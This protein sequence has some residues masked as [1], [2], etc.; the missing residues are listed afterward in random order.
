METP[1]NKIKILHCADLHLGIQPSFLKTKSK[2]RRTE[3]LLS[4]EKITSVCKAENI[5]LLIISG[6]LFESNNI[7]TKISDFVKQLLKDIP[8]TF[9]VI[10]AGNHDPLYAGSPYYDSDWPENVHIFGPQL[11]YVTVPD[12]KVRVWGVSFS[13]AYADSTLIP[14]ISVPDDDFINILALHAQITAGNSECHYNPVT[15]SQLASSGMDYAALGHIHSASGVQSAGKTYYAYPG[16]PEGQGFD[17]TGEKGVYIGYAEKGK[18]I[19]NFRKIGK[20]IFAEKNI[21]ISELAGTKQIADT[22]LAALEAGYGEDFAENLYR[23][24]LTGKYPADLPPDRNLIE[25]MLS[26]QLYYVSVKNN[27]S[28]LFNLTELAEDMSLKGAFVRN[29]LEKLENEQDLNKKNLIEKALYIG[30]KAFEGE[31]GY[32]ED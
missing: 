22:I 16:C 12:K 2:Q 1:D 17:E 23:I 14:E 21:D 29:M 8:D 19:L 13:S 3:V 10:A 31:V 24:N 4:F 7:D 26:E 5:E 30:L 32:F 9:T 18:C 11:E 28:P 6:D 27:A 25:T 20:R 15:I